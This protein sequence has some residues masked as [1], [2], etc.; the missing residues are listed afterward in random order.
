MKPTTLL[1]LSIFAIT[2][3]LNGCTPDSI[4]ESNI[5][6][7]QI[8]AGEGEELAKGIVFNDLN[9]NGLLDEGE[10]GINAILVSNGVDLVQTNSNGEY[11]IPVENDAIVFIIKPKDW[12]TAL[13]EYNLPQFY[14]R[15]NVDGSP[16]GLKYEG[17][18]ASGALPKSINF[19]LYEEKSPQEFKIAV[20]GD[21]QPYS[22]EQVDFIAEDIVMELIDRDDIA[23]GMTMGDIVGDNLDLFDP[24]NQVISKIGKP[25]YNVLGNHDMNY[26][27]PNDVHADETFERVYGPPTY[28]FEYGNTH[29]IVMDD[30]IHDTVVGSH[31]YTGGLR[32]DQLKFIENYLKTVPKEDLVILN[33]HIPFETGR[34]GYDTYRDANQKELFALLEDFPNTL[35]VSAHTHIH[36][37]IYFHKDSSAW[38]RDEPHHHYNT[39]TTCGSW[40]TGVRNE[41]DVP[42]TMMRDGTP[43]GYSI[44]N[45]KGNTYTTNWVVSGRGKD[46]VMNIHIPRGIV[47]N[48]NDT[49]MLT[50]N[51]FNGGEQSTVKY[52]IEGQ[53][54]WK[55]MERVEDYDPYYMKLVHRWKSFKK[56][57]FV[58]Q[59]EADEEANTAKFPGYRIPRPQKC[60]H[61]WQAD[62]GTNWPVGRILIE[63]EATDRYGRTFTDYQT[64]RVVAE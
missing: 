28:A 5:L 38:L 22:I 17:E 4:V 18:E 8:P 34:E 32:E 51:F 25:W 15:H 54:I 47:A 1:L 13:N 9:E 16:E 2:F 43:N 61:L 24:L 53:D 49:T 56:L 45:I 29:I 10:N 30:V 27:V 11:E 59:W 7:Y 48:A 33:M 58:E 12:E 57:E 35:S 40:W 64:M 37:N 31:G 42:H 36:D 60:T 62:I 50:V 14:Y 41:V 21:T 52:R 26:M 23:F 19:P 55:E 3:F 20:F 46:H 44:I 39:G 6:P 63:V